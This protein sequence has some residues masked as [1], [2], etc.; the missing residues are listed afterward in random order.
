[1]S[2]SGSRPPGQPQRKLVLRRKTPAEHDSQVAAPGALNEQ[3]QPQPQPH[4]LAPPPTLLPRAMR[5]MEH[6]AELFAPRPVSGADSPAGGRS[7][8]SV[9]SASRAGA[10]LTPRSG[11]TPIPL[12]S[13]VSVPPVVASVPS[14][15]I[16]HLAPKRPQRGRG[17]L[18]IGGI[19]VVA[20]LAGAILL[21]ARAGPRPAAA[22]PAPHDVVAA[23][24]SPDHPTAQPRPET[25]PDRV[26]S[27]EDLPRAPAPPRPP[28]MAAAH[29]VHAP[30]SASAHAGDV[31]AQGADTAAR[32]S[33]GAPAPSESAS[34]Q[35]AEL[36]LP[37]VPPPPAD[38]LIQAVQ[39]SIDDGRK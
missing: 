13:R 30:A 34:A 25:K 4:T 9:S 24:A 32:A 29:P 33:S 28:A 5:P 37:S 3:P 11:A 31:V 22:G 21:S 16:P 35:P 17:V 1:M 7:A 12:P 20:V 2:T 26:T 23:G 19:A 38:P 15:P 8:S 10:L 39:Q 6:S 27:V 14:N 18:V 36:E